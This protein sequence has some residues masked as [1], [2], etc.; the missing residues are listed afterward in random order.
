MT[1]R[2][3]LIEEIEKLRG[4]KNIAE[5]AL[6]R[7]KEDVIGINKKLEL[8]E[9]CLSILG[10]QE[11]VLYPGNFF[12]QDSNKRFLVKLKNGKKEIIFIRNTSIEGDHNL[13]V[14][15]DGLFYDGLLAYKLLE[16]L[17]LVSG[18]YSGKEYKD[19]LEV[20]EKIPYP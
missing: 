15:N 1:K 11:N 6:K 10:K 14:V 4:L 3:E 16:N 12:N 8:K 9:L 7:R 18:W 19:G 20:M 2:E 13:Y 5:R 17:E